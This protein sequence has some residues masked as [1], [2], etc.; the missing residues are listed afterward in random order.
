[1]SA[2]GAKADIIIPDPWA[3]GTKQNAMVGGTAKRGSPAGIARR[4]C[5]MRERASVVTKQHQ[6][7]SPVRQIKLPPP[8]A[9]SLIG[10]HRAGGLCLRLP[11]VRLT[12]PAVTLLAHVVE[13]GD[14]LAQLPFRLVDTPSELLIDPLKLRLVN[15]W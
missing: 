9:R 10:Q 6:F 3:G 5:E 11:V 13:R 2:F 4:V 12:L 8:W 7:V 15:A 14:E 1:M